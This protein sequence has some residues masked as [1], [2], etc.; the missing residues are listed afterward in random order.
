MS[1]P[2]ITEE[3]T[4]PKKVQ[5]RSPKVCWI[6]WDALYSF[7]PAV[8]VKVI[9][10]QGDED[11]IREVLE[12]CD[13]RRKAREA[14]GDDGRGLLCYHREICDQ[15]RDL[16]FARIVGAM[17]LR[18][19]MLKFRGRAKLVYAPSPTRND[20]SQGGCWAEQFYNDHP[21]TILTFT[22]KWNTLNLYKSRKLP[23]SMKGY[24]NSHL[25]AKGSHWHSHGGWGEFIP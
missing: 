25:E 12:D 13:E 8:Q 2:E 17:K 10:G 5:V 22:D 4:R 18:E 16:H 23:G 7:S 21:C 1:G 24:L 20:R 19:V 15:E 6:P 9:P 11:F 3:P 14:A